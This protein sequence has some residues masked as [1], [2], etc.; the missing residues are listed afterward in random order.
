MYTLNKPWFLLAVGFVGLAGVQLATAQT[1]TI[2]M[3]G[4][5]GGVQGPVMG[6]VYTSP[7]YA[8]VGTTA[9]VPIICDDF[10]D[11]TYF[12]ESW[13]AYVTSLSSVH[14]STPATPPGPDYDSASGWSSSTTGGPLE[15][16]GGFAGS[17][18][19]P[20]SIDLTQNQAYTVAAYLAAEI[21]ETNQSTGAGQEAA[22]DLSY[23]MWALFDPAVF[24]QNGPSCS[25]PGGEG[26]LGSTDLAAAESDLVTAYQ[27]VTSQGLN[28][29]N[30]VSNNKLNISSV[31]IYTYDSQPGVAPCTG[32]TCPPQEFISVT[33]PE[34]SMA[35][36]LGVDLLGVLGLALFA[37][38]RWAGSERS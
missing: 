37:R 10:V 17:T 29:Q 18:G 1:T 20:G 14:G 2:T 11:N 23:A 34:P 35:S 9:N 28:A 8:T 3:G 33:M 7:Y 30:F 4:D 24:L 15:W 27:A 38:R 36:L 31:T 21:V 32:A 22:G 13:T 16:G 6:G 5:P 12:S 19:A 25:L 26:C